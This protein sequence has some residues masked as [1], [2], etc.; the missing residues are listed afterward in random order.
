MEPNTTNMSNTTNTNTTNA[1]TASPTTGGDNQQKSGKKGW[2]IA[3]VIASILAIC[4]IGFGIYGMLTVSQKDSQISDLRV[5]VEDAN[6]KISTLETDKIKVSDDSQTVTITDS[7]TSQKQNPV[8]SAT[9]PK[10]FRIDF[11]SPTLPIGNEPHYVQ[12]GIQDGA[13]SSCSIF[14]R[15]G[16]GNRFDRECSGINGLSGKIYKPVVAGAG[17]DASGSNVAFIMTDGTVSYIPNVDLANGL[18]NGGTATIKG[19]LNI[20][21]FV[22]DAFTVSASDDGMSGYATTVFVLS[23]GTYVTYDDSMLN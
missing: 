23:D 9:A 7:A 2:Q 16:T 12:L 20:D 3:T 6:G 14:I 19:T 21:G 15:S 5:Q 17:Q 4:G 10:T 22:V 18:V 1:A 8:I 13:V 11:E